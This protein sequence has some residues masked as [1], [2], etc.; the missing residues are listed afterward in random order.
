MDY[1]SAIH[2]TS[3][4]LPVHFISPFNK[5]NVKKPS[6]AAKEQR[7]APHQ[8]RKSGWGDSDYAT[9]QNIPIRCNATLNSTVEYIYGEQVHDLQGTQPE[10]LECLIKTS[11]QA[12]YFATF[13]RH[14]VR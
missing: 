6:L 12:Q 10:F 7:F 11:S 4:V 9:M 1:L 3:Y 13:H 5:V 14:P 2:L 8:K